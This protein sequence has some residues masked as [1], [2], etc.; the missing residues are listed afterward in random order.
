MYVTGTSFCFMAC[1][2]FTDSVKILLSDGLFISSLLVA[3][4]CLDID[5]LYLVRNLGN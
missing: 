3:D 4:I 1:L 2:L 5:L